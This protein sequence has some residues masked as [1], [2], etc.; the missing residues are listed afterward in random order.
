MALVLMRHWI[1]MTVSNAA[2]STLVSQW[3]PTERQEKLVGHSQP[4]ML[5]DMVT[6]LLLEILSSQDITISRPCI[7]IMSLSYSNANGMD[8]SG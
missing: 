2:L 8:K 4:M 5:P 7:S 6:D 1:R 3:P